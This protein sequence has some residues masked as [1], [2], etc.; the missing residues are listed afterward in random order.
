MR[1]LDICP[2]SS[3]AEE[4]MAWLDMTDLA[5]QIDV[6]GYRVD[7]ELVA[8]EILRKLRLIKSARHELTSGSDRM[9]GPPARDR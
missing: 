4:T 6:H 5:Q 3:G 2:I 8:I 7:P 9:P 1:I